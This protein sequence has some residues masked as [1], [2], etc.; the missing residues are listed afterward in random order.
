MPKTSCWAV[1]QGI[2]EMDPDERY[3]DLQEIIHTAIERHLSRVWTAL[4]V[5]LTA[6]GDGFTVQ[7]QPT[8]KGKQA[9]PKTGQLSDV[10]MP[11]LGSSVPV[12]YPSGGGFTITHPVKQDDE[13]IAVFSSRCIDGWWDK[14]GLQP[15]LETRRHNLSDGMYI[16][17]VRSK[18]RKLNPGASTTTLQIRTDKGDVYVE[19]TSDSVNIV[20]TQKVTVK[21]VEMDVTATSKVAITSPVVTMSGNLQVEGTISAGGQIASGADVHAAG[22]VHAGDSSGLDFSGGEAASPAIGVTVG[23]VTL[24]WSQTG[25]PTISG[26][27][28]PGVLNVISQVATHVGA[29]GDN[30]SI[31]GALSLVEGQ[32]P[33]GTALLN[34][35]FQVASIVNSGNF[36]ALLS[37]LPGQLSHIGGVPQIKAFVSLLDHLHHG[38]MSGSSLSQQ[39]QT[40]T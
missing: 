21:C 26:G 2:C 6:D 8:I 4:P 34:Q 28:A 25:P 36:T 18:P 29:I 20:A 13:G 14:G 11:S 35:A 37:A 27:P 5:K 9:D 10:A 32:I 3:D 23:G 15:Q 22:D 39:P 17:G 38:V 30:F 40:G 19:V 16:P 24:S 7:A 31:S 12:H 33:G 1:T